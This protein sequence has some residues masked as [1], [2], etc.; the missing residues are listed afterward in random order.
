LATGLAFVAA[1][2][3]RTMLIDADPASGGLDLLLGAERMPGWRWPR[4]ATACGHLGDLTSQLPSVDGIDLLSMGRSESPAGWAPQAEQLKAVLRSAMRSHE[5]TVVDLSRTLGDAAE[6]ALR[7]AE[8][9]VL[10]VRDDVRGI[11]AGREVARRLGGECGGLGIVVRHGKAHRLEPDVVAGAVGLPLLG[12]FVEDPM[13]ALAAERGDPPGRSGRN[14]LS[15]LCRQLL[16][17]LP[18]TGATDER[19]R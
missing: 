9:T 15:R 10:V 5:T 3:K 17:A 19:R 16:D 1:R 13:L 11:A 4:L 12:S 6:E 2:T 8:L 14:G 18:D 7:R